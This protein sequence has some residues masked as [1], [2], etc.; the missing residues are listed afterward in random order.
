MLDNDIVLKAD[1]LYLAG[2]KDTDGSGERATGIYARDTRFVS[3]LDVS[4][5][6]QALK[7]LAIRTPDANRALFVA[8]NDGFELD[9]QEVYGHSLGVQQELSLTDEVTLA[10]TVRNHTGQ[11]MAPEFGVTV[12]SD[13]RDLFAIRGFPQPEPGVYAPVA[14]SADRIELGYRPPGDVEV[15]ISVTFSERPA[16]ITEVN[17]ETGDQ[18][19]DRARS[20]PVFGP[21]G[22]A[23]P[24]V[25]ARATFRPALEPHA[26]WHL[27]VTIR[28]RTVGDRPLSAAARLPSHGHLQPGRIRTS[29]PA[30]NAV[31]DR[32]TADLA[33]LQTTFD[34]GSIIAAGIPWFV[35]PFGRDSLIAGFQTL[36]LSPWRTAGILRVLAAH[37]ATSHDPWRDREPGKI[38]HEVRYGEMARGGTIPHTPYYGTVDATPLFAWLV[39]ETVAWTGDGALWRELEPHARAAVGWMREWGDLDGDGLIEHPTRQP[40]G[41]HITNQGWKDSWDSLHHA[42]GS[43]PTGNI[44]LVEVQGYAYAAYRRLADISRLHGDTAWA[45]EL[46]GYASQTRA[47]VE[48]GFWV[49]EMGTYAQALD[50]DKRPVAVVSSNPGH[51]LL[52]GLPSPERAAS[53][54]RVLSHPSMSSGWGLRT[55]A[56]TAPTYNPMSYHNGSVWPHDNSLVVGGLASSGQ[57]GIAVELFEAL[58]A[59]ALTDPT[60]RLPE[61][62]CGFPRLGIA[63]SAPVP[64]PV[65]CI[66][67]AWAA[68]AIPF[69]LTSLLGLAITDDGAEITVAPNLPESIDWVEVTGLR[70]GNADAT[71]RV[72][73]DG[74]GYAV[75]GTGAI[76]VALAGD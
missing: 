66:P 51:L 45:D 19:V 70:A 21:S 5:N 17:E 46:D 60:R 49:E 1:E 71:V 44:A 10:L 37:Q 11:S 68:G 48:D 3:V 15:G 62:F 12:G 58:L 13:F 43:V 28:L 7:T 8:T 27:T 24:G 53:M 41:V 47:L 59:A 26:T 55:L 29:D 67:Q 61:L 38:L 14:V 73:R 63:E 20:S 50:G 16:A 72:R 39:A 9:G 57:H 54:A 76:G 2:A 52:A 22:R 36:P 6:G 30:L 18:N 34:E 64:Y 40:D 25:A 56:T 75:E 42:D 65:S 31:L 32:A 69:M 33:M 4:L 74:D 23:L 35:A